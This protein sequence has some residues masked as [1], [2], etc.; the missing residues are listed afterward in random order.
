MCPLLFFGRACNFSHTAHVSGSSGR[1]W[2]A[3]FE[4]FKKLITINYSVTGE[5]EN[6]STAAYLHNAKC[7]PLLNTR[8]NL[9]C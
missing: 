8:I 9:N 6:S 2:K 1:K 5:C 4:A 7:N 3:M